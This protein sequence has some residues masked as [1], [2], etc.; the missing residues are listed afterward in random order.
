MIQYFESTL[1]PDENICKTT[2]YVSFIN[3]CMLFARKEK[4]HDEEVAYI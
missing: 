4:D 3:L 1:L 2:L